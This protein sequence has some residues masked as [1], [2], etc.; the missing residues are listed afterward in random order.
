M[1]NRITINPFHFTIQQTWQ[2]RT[3]PYMADQ[4]YAQ[5]SEARA[6]RD[7]KN[8]LPSVSSVVNVVS[9]QEDENVNSSLENG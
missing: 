2:N 8:G 5:Y 1:H 7:A 3:Q 9:T 6:H 4:F